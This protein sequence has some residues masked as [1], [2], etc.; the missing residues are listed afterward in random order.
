[1]SQAETGVHFESEMEFGI[2]AVRWS[3]PNKYAI[4]DGFL[5]NEGVKTAMQAFSKGQRL[6][7]TKR[8]GLFPPARLRDDGAVWLGELPAYTTKHDVLSSIPS[9]QQ[10]P[11]R[12]VFVLE[13]P[14]H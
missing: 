4:L 12:L 6:I 9:T 7:P 1:M 5:S 14:K 2:F 3:R 13:K 11:S 10:Q 8:G